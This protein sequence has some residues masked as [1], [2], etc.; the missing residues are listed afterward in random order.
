MKL[1]AKAAAIIIFMTLSITA[2]ADSINW[3]QYSPNSVA[4]AKRDNHLLL[5]FAMSDS[6]QHCHKMRYTTLSDNSVAHLI[7]SK[8]YPVLLKTDEDEAAVQK[9]QITTVPRIIIVNGNGKVIQTISGFK[10]PGV[11]EKSLNKFCSTLN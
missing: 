5:I 2:Y 8:F 7:N 4:E 11:L 9:Y 6:C 1:L 10:L 3:H